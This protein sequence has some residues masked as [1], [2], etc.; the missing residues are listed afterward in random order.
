MNSF[1]RRNFLYCIVYTD[2]IKK[3][4]IS[5][6]QDDIE[7]IVDLSDIRLRVE[8]GLTEH[9]HAGNRGFL[10]DSNFINLYNFAII[11]N[12]R[13]ANDDWKKAKE[14][15]QE[16]EFINDSSV[17]LKYADDFK[18]LSLE[19]K[20]S[21]INQAKAFAKYM[22]EIGCFYTDK[23]VDFEQVERFTDE[24]LVKIGLLEH[25][26]WLQEHYD[27]GWTYGNPEKEKRDFER[28][29][30]DMIPEF[31]KFDVSDEEAKCNYERLDKET[32]DKDS[33]PMECM[34]S[35]LKMFDGLRIYRIAGK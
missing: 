32:Q 3:D 4:G 8:T 16:D 26:R 14:A 34:L 21:N 12:G 17:L 30:R 35:L 18:N 24:E 20:I 19:Y 11:L 29:H 23:T 31:G 10:S 33:E 1:V 6:F 25:R 5:V 22:N 7:R 28:R 2:F 9:V 13:W 27:M 15:G